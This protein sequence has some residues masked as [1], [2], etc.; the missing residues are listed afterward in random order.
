M[1]T[2]LVAVNDRGRVIGEDHPRAVLSNHEIYLL[3]EMHDAGWGYNRLAKKFEIGKSTVR[4]ICK[5]LNRQQSVAG[6]RRVPATVRTFSEELVR[7]CCLVKPRPSDKNRRVRHNYRWVPPG[8]AQALLAA[9]K[10]YIP[11]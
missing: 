2:H 11:T 4:D 1:Q 3:L 8:E 7:V 5:G 10:A 6:S 9:G